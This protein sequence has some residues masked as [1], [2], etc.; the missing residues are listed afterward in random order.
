ML[1]IEDYIPFESFGVEDEDETAGDCL[2]VPAGAEFSIPPMPR[3]R[4]SDISRYVDTFL[5][6]PKFVTMQ[7][8]P[9]L[10]GQCTA[11]SALHPDIM[12]VK[13]YH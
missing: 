8:A 12:I 9:E 5:H 2:S 3:N 7:L 11:S 1:G 10:I 13:L 4:P 6:M